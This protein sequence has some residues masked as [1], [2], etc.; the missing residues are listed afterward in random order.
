[1]ESAAHITVLVAT[2]ARPTFLF[3]LL[4]SLEERVGR[5]EKVDI[6][7]YVDE[8][9]TATL[10]FSQSHQ[11]VLP[12]CFHVG[13]R[14]STMGEMIHQLQRL[15]PESDIYVTTVDDTLFLTPAWDEAI[16]QAYASVPDGIALAYVDDLNGDAGSVSLVTLSRAW[17]EASGA[18]FTEFFPFWFDDSWLDQIAMMVGR[19]LPL[20]V[21]AVTQSQGQQNR[22][23]RMRNLAF[24]DR[25]YF[26]TLEDR[27]AAARRL[28]ARIYAG[29]PEALQRQ[30]RVMEEMVAKF[31]RRETRLDRAHIQY[32]EFNRATAARFE[33]P[34]PRYCRAEERAVCH[35]AQKARNWLEQG[36]QR[37]AREVLQGLPYAAQCYQG[38]PQEVVV[39]GLNPNPYPALS[40]REKL[41]F[42]LLPITLRW[43]RLTRILE[44]H[45]PGQWPRQ[46]FELMRR[47]YLRRREKS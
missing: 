17:I 47:F 25:F 16:R 14:T 20:P 43:R 19:K 40:S 7:V 42:R 36:Q 31:R 41:R 13:P 11:A 33:A 21:E 3:R 32:V 30:S 2:R 34:N 9:D 6:A 44:D 26:H 23:S 46:L 45:P 4:R 5:S 27:E 39:S 37:R 8:D 28:M 38:L 35:L 12:T 22:T 1:M 24:W 18:M 10:D 15:R 29:Q